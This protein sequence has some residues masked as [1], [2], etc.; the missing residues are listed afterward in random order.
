MGKWWWMKE[1][2]QDN[3]WALREERTGRI[4]GMS[5]SLSEEHFLCQ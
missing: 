2:K 4:T 5:T 1:E 3:G